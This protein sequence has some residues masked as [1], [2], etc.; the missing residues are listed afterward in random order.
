MSS[1]DSGVNSLATVATMDYYRRFFHTPAKLEDHYLTAG[2][3]STAVIGVLAT[4]AALFVGKLG[5]IIE[6]ICKINGSLTGPL[7]ALFLLGLFAKRANGPGAFAGTLIGLFTVLLVGQTDVFWGWYAPL[8][9]A[10]SLVS[11]YV[12]S[13]VWS[14]F[15]PERGSNHKREGLS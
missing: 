8:G 10:T 12:L 14:S 11:G 4:T 15:M 9:L 7:L 1:V 5:T 13:L 3:V 6:I 2:R